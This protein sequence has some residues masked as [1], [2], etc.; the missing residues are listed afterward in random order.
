[1]CFKLYYSIFLKK[2][3][4]FNVPIIDKL[5]I[6]YMCLTNQKINKMQNKLTKM[7]IYNI[8]LMFTLKFK[9]LFKIINFI[10]ISIFYCGVLIII[11]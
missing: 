5:K 9:C 8:K 4:L 2:E 3:K 7:S 11:K 6:K 10:F 1:M